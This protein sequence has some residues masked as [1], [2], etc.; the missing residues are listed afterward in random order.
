MTG[1]N[2]A[3][4]VM[5]TH[6]YAEE[7]PY[8]AQVTITDPNGISSPTISD[9]VTV[10]DAAL[11]V[12]NSGVYLQA[13]QGIALNGVPVAQ[14]NDA[15]TTESASSFTATI[16][17]GDN[18]SPTT[19]VVSGAGGLFSVSGSHAYAVQGSYGV[20]VTIKDA[21]GS[22]VIASATA[23][24]AAPPIYTVAYFT[25]SN[26]SDPASSFAAVIN[27]GDGTPTSNGT[28]TGSSGTF[29]V[30]AGHT[31][32]EERQTPYP[33][34]VTITGPGGPITVQST[35]QVSDAPQVVAQAPQVP[36]QA[37]P[38]AAVVPK[39]SI[40]MTSSGASIYSVRR[41]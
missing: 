6:T 29:T 40:L 34:S 8:T 11:K 18:T 35:A 15:N 19:G 3:F 22:Q 4:S 33:V 5:D 25:D 21:G 9:A 23:T 32:A 37:Q 41:P 10:A 24:V 2:G 30:T 39:L 14:F 16:N 36:P 17:W 26:S 38:P 12:N 31:Y 1:S 13:T 20:T 28:V 27:W 7:G